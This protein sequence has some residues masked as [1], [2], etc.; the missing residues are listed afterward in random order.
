M[1]DFYNLISPYL[2][3]QMKYKLHYWNQSL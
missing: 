2:I 1:L 3:P